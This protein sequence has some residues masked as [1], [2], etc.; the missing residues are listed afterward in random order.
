MGPQF[1]GKEW[2]EFEGYRRRLPHW[3]LDGATY[4]LTWRVFPGQHD[5]TPE[6]RTFVAGALRFFDGTRYSLYAYVVM[7]DHVHVL[8]APQADWK[9]EQLTHTWKSFTTNQ[10]QKG[11]AGAVP[12]KRA[13]WQDETFDRIVRDSSEFY[14]KLYYIL[15]N[16]FKRWPEISVYQWTWAQDRLAAEVGLKVGHRGNG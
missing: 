11:K 14:E 2:G 9:L 15:N 3:R 4:F 12:R 5:L 7:N 16:P 13:L 6:E 10:L 8:V 1:P